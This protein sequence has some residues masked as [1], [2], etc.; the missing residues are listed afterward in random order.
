MPTYEDSFFAR[1]PKKNS[2]K[3]TVDTLPA[4]QARQTKADNDVVTAKAIAD[5]KEK[6]L[7]KIVGENTFK[8]ADI[9]SEDVD[10]N[11]I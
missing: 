3:S 8:Y 7:W 9:K 5:V 4:K 10:Q 6:A 11:N 2:T 1:Y